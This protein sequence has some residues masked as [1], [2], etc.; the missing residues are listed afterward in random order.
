MKAAIHL[1]ALIAGAASMAIPPSPEIKGRYT[2]DTKRGHYPTVDE[3]SP[4]GRS[5]ISY[6]ND[7]EDIPE[8]PT[9]DKTSTRGQWVTSYSNEKEDVPEGQALDQ[10]GTSTGATEHKGATP[11]PAAS[12]GSKE[13][14]LPDHWLPNGPGYLDMDEL[15]KGYH[16]HLMVMDD[17][18][19]WLYSSLS[20]FKRI[21]KPDSA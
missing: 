16:A 18:S 17:S 21:F 12:F 8:G 1:T 7:K 4:Q 2:H 19:S 11:S 5:V 6:L 9:V 3:T 14:V 15:E 20:L 13:W 10:S